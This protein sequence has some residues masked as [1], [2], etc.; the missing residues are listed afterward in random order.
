M[1]EQFFVINIREYLDKNDP[2]KI[3]EDKIYKLLLSFSCPLNND[4][5]RFLKHNAIEFTKKD[6]SVT[7]LVFRYI[8]NDEADFVGY[9]TLAV[10]T[11]SIH[12]SAISKS[13]ARKLD[14]ISTLDEKTNTYTASAYLIAQLGK[15]FAL[16]E[17]RRINGNA[18]LELAFDV[19]SQAK[20]LLGGVIEFLEC[21][22][23]EALMNFYTRN[24]FRFFN[25]RITQGENPHTLNQLLKF[26]KS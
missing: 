13:M 22:N 12:S 21:E 7:Y 8:S 14:R 9:F 20:Y 6:Q 19:I 3:I 24:G 17:E 18:L 10:K 23:N 4:V 5:E 1:S 26:I 11:V 25:S 16:P 2:A 15:N